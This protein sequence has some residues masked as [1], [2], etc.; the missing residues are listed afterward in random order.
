[1]TEQRRAILTALQG[2]KTHPTADELCS[3]V[4]KSLPHI[5]LGT[6]YRN[7]EFLSDSGMIRKLDVGG[8]QMRFD[9]NP[10]THYHVRCLDCGRVDDLPAPPSREI[11]KLKKS[12]N[13]YEVLDYNLEFIGR[14]P[15]CRK[16]KKRNA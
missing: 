15:T 5:S 1:M 13:G 2:V 4:R 7:L 14:C 6:V 9:G 8:A 3:M 16:R 12:V 10:S 11:E